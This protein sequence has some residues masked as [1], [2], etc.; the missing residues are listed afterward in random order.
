MKP[1]ENTKSWSEIRSEIKKKFTKLSDETLD[2]LNESFDH[3]SEKVQYAYGMAKDKAD[4]EIEQLK[5]SVH[6]GAEELRSD[7]AAAAKATTANVNA[8]KKK[9]QNAASE[10]RH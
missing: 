8:A 9:N 10:R 1:I 6:R 5:R 7:T 4:R 2:S 3:L